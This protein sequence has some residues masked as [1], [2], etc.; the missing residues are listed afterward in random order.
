VV[1]IGL[2]LGAVVLGISPTPLPVGVPSAVPG[3]VPVI[4]P[5]IVSEPVPANVSLGSRMGEEWACTIVEDNLNLVNLVCQKDAGEESL[6]FLQLES[7]NTPEADP[8]GQ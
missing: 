8:E 3:V 5:A 4:A 6:R 2:T 7:G 1:L